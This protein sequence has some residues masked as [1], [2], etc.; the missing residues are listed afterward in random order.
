MK[1]KVGAI[2]VTH[3]ASGDGFASNGDRVDLV[4]KTA[5]GNAY[6]RPRVVDLK[7]IYSMKTASLI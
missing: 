3:T 6:S 7:L 4:K 5:H 1:N 2:L